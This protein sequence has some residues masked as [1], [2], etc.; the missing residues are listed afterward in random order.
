MASSG[1]LSMGKEFVRMGTFTLEFAPLSR[2]MGVACQRSYSP[3]ERKEDEEGPRF[4]CRGG[5]SASGELGS[6]N[7]CDRARSLERSP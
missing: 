3:R 1:L 4:L 2:P 6:G 7:S 5:L